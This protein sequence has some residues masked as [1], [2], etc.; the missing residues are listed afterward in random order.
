[1]ELYLCFPLHLPGVAG[2]TFQLSKMQQC[3]LLNTRSPPHALA[4][5]D[6]SDAACLLSF[7]RAPQLSRDMPADAGF[8][9]HKTAVLG[10]TIKETACRQPPQTSCLGLVL[11]RRNTAEYRRVLFCWHFRLYVASGNNHTA[12][13]HTH[14]YIYICY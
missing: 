5:F 9:R 8:L 12:R 10:E 3:H 1:M 4:F 7:P 6:C 2:T 11:I 14:I 13:A